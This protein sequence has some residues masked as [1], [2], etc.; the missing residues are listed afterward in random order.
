MEGSTYGGN[1]LGCAVAM[2]ALQVVKDE[3]L[4]TRAAQLGEKFREALRNIKSPIIH[5]IRGK[6]L[7]NAIV[8]DE[9][10]CYG[11]TAWQ[12]CLMLKSK[13]VLAKPTHKVCISQTYSPDLIKFRI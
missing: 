11:K 7:L 10:K 2:A 12:I 3:G 6:G 4:V 13:G 9:S 5:T 1:P 8:I